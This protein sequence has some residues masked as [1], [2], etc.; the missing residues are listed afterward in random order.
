M[1]ANADP[2]FDVAP[3]AQRAGKQ[4]KGFGFR[5]GHFVT[6]NTNMNDLI[7][8]PTVSMPSRLST[9]LHGSAPTSS[10]LK[11]TRHRRPPNL[12]QMG[13]MVQKLLTERFLLKFHKDKRELSVYANHRSSRWTQ[14]DQN[15]VCTR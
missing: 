13:I 3:S 5:A 12:K 2:G 11:P 14:D 9:R 7:A 8:S 6:F 15:H 1:A 4:G 10:T